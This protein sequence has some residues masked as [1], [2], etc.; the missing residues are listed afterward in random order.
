MEQQQKKICPQCSSE[1][2]PKNIGSHPQVYCSKTCRYNANNKRRASKITE[3]ENM[4]KNEQQ[5]RDTST[6]GSD[7]IQAKQR[8]TDIPVFGASSSSS[9]SP[10]SLIE[11]QYDAKVVALEYKLRYEELERRYKQLEQENVEL[12][13][14]LEEAINESDNKPSGGFLGEILPPDTIKQVLPLVLAKY[15]K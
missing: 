4:L 6:S 9:L 7:I 15:L 5:N 14:D 11:K 8:H 10:Y 2:E 13:I 3:L 1:F 12:Q